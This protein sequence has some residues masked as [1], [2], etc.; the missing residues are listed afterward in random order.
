MHSIAEH[1]ADF[2]NYF[3]PYYGDYLIRWLSRHGFL[4]FTILGRKLRNKALDYLRRHDLQIDDHGVLHTYDLVLTCQDLIV[5]KNI[6]GR[7]I[8]LVQEGMTDPEGFAYHL[9]KHLRLPRYFASTSAT[10]QSDRYDYF[11]VASEGYRDLFIRKGLRPE[12]LV[13]TGIPNFDDCAQYR[14]NT[15]PHRNFVLVATS[16][17]RETF[18][19]ENRR[20]FIR[21]AIEIAAGRKLIFKLHPNENHERAIREIGEQAADAIVYSEGNTNQMIANCDVLITR[22]SSVVYVG[23]ALGKI[24]HSEFDLRELRT[25][26]PIQNSGTSAQTI[27]SLC[28]DF[29][30]RDVVAASSPQHGRGVRPRGLFPLKQFSRSLLQLRG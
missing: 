17:S 2:D 22:Y 4:E 9:V 26:M 30:L 28:R 16:D 14:N 13:V 24:V 25:Q 20:K 21:Q 11:C 27:A 6:R 18:R 12:K 5:P 19:Y 15:F 23:L 3:T 29:L 1:L 8:V 10:G 7:K